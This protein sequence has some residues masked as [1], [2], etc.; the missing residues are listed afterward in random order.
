MFIFDFDGVI[1][2]SLA[3]YQKA[4]QAAAAMQNSSIQL[5]SNPFTNLS[6]V[7][8]EA[9]AESHQLDPKRFS[10]DVTEHIK[11]NQLLPPLFDDMA[12]TLEVLAQSQAIFIL[13]ATHTSV[14][15]SICRHHH[16]A[17]YISGMIGG[18]ISGS[19]GEKITQLLKPKAAH[20]ETVIMVGDSVSDIDA[21]H[22]ANIPAVGVT[23]GWQSADKLRSHG[24][25]H[26]VDTPNQL[27]ELLIQLSNASSS[28]LKQQ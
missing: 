11:T 12:H 14:L 21:A 5:P 28:P 4:C 1:A 17:Q 6:I 25:D 10:S 2:D 20:G 15:Q 19:K 22:A 16:I 18:D 23:W 3:C 9:L 7:T 13:S 27:L 8:F 26:M 24:A